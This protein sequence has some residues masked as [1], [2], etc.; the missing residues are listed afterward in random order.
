M[1]V[2]AYRTVGKVP[3]PPKYVKFLSARRPTAPGM[4]ILPPEQMSLSKGCPIPIG[5]K[6][7][8]RGTTTPPR[9]THGF[10]RDVI[11]DIGLPELLTGGE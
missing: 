3:P 10:K 5:G 2:R 11:R 8:S 9:A 4:P 1:H 7:K 6:A